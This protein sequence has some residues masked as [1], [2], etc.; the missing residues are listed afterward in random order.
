MSVVYLKSILISVLCAA[1]G[2]LL[3]I[4]T[5]WSVYGAFCFLIGPII[6]LI[7]AWIYIYKHIDST[8]NR[9][10]LFLLNPVLYYLI[11]LI[12]ILTLLYIEVAENGF[13]PWNY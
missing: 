12:V 4:V 9:I 2:F 6:G 5:F 7:I 10:K 1:I 13:H 11:F 8:K 3:G